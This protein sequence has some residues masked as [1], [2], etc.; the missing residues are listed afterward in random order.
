MGPVTLA[1]DHD[2]VLCAASSVTAL[3]GALDG[4]PGGGALRL[5]AASLSGGELAAAAASQAGEWTVEMY[6]LGAA[7]ARYSTALER[8][9]DTH[10]AQ[11]AAGAAGLSCPP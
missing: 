7:F 4:A 3:A 5:V 9:V 2:S 8:A 10:R 11:D 6:E 1:I